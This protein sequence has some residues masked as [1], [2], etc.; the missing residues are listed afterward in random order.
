MNINLFIVLLLTIVFCKSSFSQNSFDFYGNVVPL[1]VVSPQECDNMVKESKVSVDL[2]LYINKY[3]ML[4]NLEDWPIVLF[5]KK[6][7]AAQFSNL[8]RK[9]KEKIL[10]ILITSQNFNNAI[11]S[12]NK[13]RLLSIIKIE[14]NLMPEG[15]QVIDNSGS[16]FI[17]GAVKKEPF[18]IKYINSMLHNGKD[19]VLRA[20]PAKLLISDSLDATRTFYN[21]KT[22]LLDSISFSYSPTFINYSNDFPLA[23]SH[24]SYKKLPISPVFVNSF[25]NSLTPKLKPCINLE[26]S[27]NFL[28]RFTQTVLKYKKNFKI[29]SPE[30]ALQSAYGDCADYSMLLAFLLS[31]YFNNL[32]IVFLHYDLINHVRLGIYNPKFET[33]NKSFVEFKEK[34]YLLAELTNELLLGDYLFVGKPLYP[35]QILH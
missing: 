29:F 7:V 24:V 8:R 11:G 4:Y 23:L 9:D 10:S 3:I 27:V 26:D 30:N 6:F 5:L 34:K 25:F 32:D 35:N 17:I 15:I 14:S 31:Y 16:R 2:Q 19:I 21:Y 33:K 1:T 18:N 22:K 13:H 12:K 20:K 28:M